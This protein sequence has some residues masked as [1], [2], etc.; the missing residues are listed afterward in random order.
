MLFSICY[1]DNLPEQVPSVSVSWAGITVVERT[2]A[3]MTKAV[4]VD[5]TWRFFVNIGHVSHKRE[6]GGGE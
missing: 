5:K 3:L 2:L 6:R 1:F 4:E